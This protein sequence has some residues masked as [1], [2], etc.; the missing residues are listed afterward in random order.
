M[1]NI[2]DAF[3]YEVKK[4]C[5]KH[6]LFPSAGDGVLVA[7][8]GGGDSVAL[9][10][11]L[12][13]NRDTL[14]FRIEAAHLNHALRGADSDGD[15]D[16][17]RA[18]CAA[19]DIPLIVHTLTEGELIESRDSIEVSARNA[20]IAFLEQTAMTNGLSRIA[21]GHTMNDQV[22]TVLQ[23]MIR[24][25][26]PAGLSGIRP[27]RNDRW[28]RPLLATSREDARSYLAALG[29][30]FRED[31]TN[32]DPAFFRNRIRTNCYRSCGSDSLP[33]SSPHSSGWRNFPRYRKITWNIRSTRRTASFACVITSIKYYLI[34]LSLRVI[35]LSFNS[36]WYVVASN[37]SK[38]GTLV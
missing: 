21:T 13:R 18:L 16:F 1:N 20:R 4:Y 26:G 37:V 35:M 17:C 11:V 9:L 14:G 15:E 34:K 38:D 23:R 22:E 29:Q 8:S 28:I 3:E 25:T 12:A 7:L 30:S 33:V 32:S 19:M 10:T 5:I 31:A 24:G 6:A 27:I 2:I 36:A